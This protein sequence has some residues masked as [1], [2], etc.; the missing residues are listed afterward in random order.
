[1]KKTLFIN[2]ERNKDPI[3]REKRFFLND[4]IKTDLETVNELFD[5]VR[6]SEKLGR[7]QNDKEEFWSKEQIISL[8]KRIYKFGMYDKIIEKLNGLYSDFG[9]D[10]LFKI[11]KE[12]LDNYYNSL[13]DRR[14]IASAGMELG[15]RLSK[16]PGQLITKKII[17]FDEKGNKVKSKNRNWS[18]F[19]TSKLEEVYNEYLKASDKWLFMEGVT[20]VENEELPGFLKVE[21]DNSQEYSKFIQWFKGQSSKLSDNKIFNYMLKDFYIYSKLKYCEAYF[22]QMKHENMAELIKMQERGELGLSV[23]DSTKFD[24]KFI[25]DP[26]E[27][28]NTVLIRVDIPGHSSAYV[29]HS[30]LDRLNKVLGRPETQPLNLEESNEMYIGHGMFSY[31]LT[32][33]QIEFLRELDF[34]NLTSVIPRT[35]K[36]LQYMRTSIYEQNEFEIRRKNMK[37]KTSR[38]GGDDVQKN[39][40]RRGR[41]SDLIEDEPFIDNLCKEIKEKLGIEIPED[42]K[43]KSKGSLLYKSETQKLK[44]DGMYSYMKAFLSEKL[45]SDRKDFSEEILT[46]ETNKMFVYM[47][48]YGKGFWNLSYIDKRNVILEKAYEEYGDKFDVIVRAMQNDEVPIEKLKDYVKK[49]TA[50]NIKNGASKENKEFRATRGTSEKLKDNKKSKELEKANEEEISKVEPSK[51]EKEVAEAE[52][53]GIEETS[54]GLNN[55]AKEEEKDKKNTEKKSN[56]DIIKEA[57]KVSIE[58]KK[59]QL[60]LKLNELVLLEEEIKRLEKLEKSINGEYGIGD[61]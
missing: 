50:P 47:K 7:E 57:L 36:M 19:Y 22:Y 37:L 14:E 41:K 45:P 60:K 39:T 30:K 10:D 34:R 6:E 38:Q 58:T 32:E 5:F 21:K 44:L 18:K 48:L 56:E 35:R 40:K 52:K 24:K 26:K 13:I 12:F 28:Q 42:Y 25:K 53:S 4:E 59:E 51:V 23:T 29:L 33:K 15:N 31:K 46:N 61:D 17:Q 8:Y 20:L 49:K 16:V 3:N 9:R 2:R 43:G 1:M 11:D 54:K 27:R 55:I